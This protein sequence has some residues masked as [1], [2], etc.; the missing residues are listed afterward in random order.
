LSS[1]V[2]SL[3]GMSTSVNFLYHSVSAIASSTIVYA[4]T[5]NGLV[6][7]SGDQGVTW[8]IDQSFLLSVVFYSVSVFSDSSALLGAAS[9]SFIY[10]RNFGNI[11]YI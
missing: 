7:R 2:L 11:Y 10:Q 8:V 1:S 3:P 6:L 9:S 5:S 4:A